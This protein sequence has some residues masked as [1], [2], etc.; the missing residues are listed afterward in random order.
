MRGIPKHRGRHRGPWADGCPAPPLP[1]NR[2]RCACSNWRYRGDRS[3]R[4]RSP[5]DRAACRMHWQGVFGG[6]RGGESAPRAAA[7]NRAV[8]VATHRQ[9][10]LAESV[11]FPETRSTAPQSTRSIA[12]AGEAVPEHGQAGSPNRSNHRGTRWPEVTERSSGT[13]KTEVQREATAISNENREL[14][15]ASRQVKIVSPAT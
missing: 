2:Y 14:R 15:F 9:A 5:T 6:N 13:H 10:E 4:L 7:G 11:E 8:P 12:A 1:P 3:A